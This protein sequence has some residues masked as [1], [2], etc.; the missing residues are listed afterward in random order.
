MA[1]CDINLP[2]PLPADPFNGLLLPCKHKGNGR[3]W[4]FLMTLKP[5]DSGADAAG[6]THRTHD[7]SISANQ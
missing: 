3:C 5:D 2:D 6:D 4:L 1:H 7:V